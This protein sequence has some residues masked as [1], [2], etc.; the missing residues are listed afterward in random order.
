MYFRLNLKIELLKQN[1]SIE[2]L[3]GVLKFSLKNS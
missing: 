1:V 2:R 3:F